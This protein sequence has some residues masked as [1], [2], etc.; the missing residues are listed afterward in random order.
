MLI[1]FSNGNTLY[2][3]L[4]RIKIDFLGYFEIHIT[5]MDENIDQVIK[6]ENFKR[7]ASSESKKY[8]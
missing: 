7:S 1:L 8:D 6:L 2:S 5:S 3:S 4:L